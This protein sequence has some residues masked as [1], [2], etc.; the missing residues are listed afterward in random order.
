MKKANPDYTIN[1]LC[2]LLQL[3]TRT[4]YA[5]IQHKPVNHKELAMIVTIKSIANET[6][7]TYGK[8]RMHASLKNQG[9]KLGLD[10]T[11][12]LMKKAAIQAIKPKKKHY[13]PNA[14]KAHRKAT[15]IL[16]RQFSP[17]TMNTHWTGDITYVSTNQGWSYLACVLDLATKEIVGWAM[18]K[19]PNAEL[20]KTALNR[21][22]IKQRPNTAQLLF[23]SDQGTQYS[24]KLFV[25]YLDTLKINQ[26]MS[27]RGN[28]WD[29]SVMERFFRSLK[30]ERLNH[31]SITTHFAAV[32][33]IESYIYFYNYKR[34]HSSLGYIAPVQ[35]SAKLRKVA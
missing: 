14:G 19:T 25:D 28:C 15:N 35:M 29:N 33:C 20:A 30:S 26:S 7:H 22:I 4:Y 32:S 11:R 17:K 12:T 9:F 3:S 16:A 21:A 31:I 27:R 34:L 13:Y 6:G 18:S 1:E 24:A 8:R 2:A 23:H 5:Q 10:K